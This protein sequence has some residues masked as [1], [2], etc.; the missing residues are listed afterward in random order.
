MLHKMRN[1]QTYIQYVKTLYQEKQLIMT[2]L[3]IILESN[4]I[5]LLK[6]AFP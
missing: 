5:V 3:A 6:I 2:V 1:S 4:S